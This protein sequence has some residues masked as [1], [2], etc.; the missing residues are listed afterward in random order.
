MSMV[1]KNKLR[2]ISQLNDVVS[3]ANDFGGRVCKALKP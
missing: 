2:M 3:V 1:V